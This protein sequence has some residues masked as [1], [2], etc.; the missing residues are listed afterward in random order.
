[1][2]GVGGIV[3]EPVAVRVTDGVL[4]LER[5]A[6]GVGD[7]LQPIGPAPAK[8]ACASAPAT[9]KKRVAASG[10]A[11]AAPPA[12]A[13]PVAC[14][15]ANTPP[16]PA[17]NTTPCSG[18]A[19]TYDTAAANVAALAQVHAVAVALVRVQR[20]SAVVPAA[21]NKTVSEYRSTSLH[22][23]AEGAPLSVC[24]KHIVVE[25]A[26]AADVDGRPAKAQNTPDVRSA[27]RFPPNTT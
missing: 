10:T 9:P 22:V 4:E 5:V 12:R 8:G 25:S 1:M 7:A 15:K 23:D 27:K 16:G 18:A 17:A 6:E 20:D 19:P 2:L 24:V 21:R 3:A 13:T 11:T 14:E 26:P